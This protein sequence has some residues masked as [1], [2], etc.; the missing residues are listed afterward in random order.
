MQLVTTYRVY[1][2]ADKMPKETTRY[3]FDPAK[4]KIE[5]EKD[6]IEEAE[7]YCD[8]MNPDA[9]WV[10]MPNHELKL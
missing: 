9:V 10:I 6:T 8:M 2:I 4:H 1:K 5:I 7:K 3:N